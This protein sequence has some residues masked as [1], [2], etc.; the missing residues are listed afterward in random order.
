[1]PGR[2]G[3]ERDHLTK[4][5]DLT[6]FPG[7]IP[8][9][10]GGILDGWKTPALTGWLPNLRDFM[11]A[12]GEL[13][14]ERASINDAEAILELQK[15]AY[16][17]EAELLD[18]FTIPP[19]H[20]TTEEILAEFDR[21]VFLKVELEGRIIASVRCHLEDRT[22]HVGKLI[23][24]PDLRN[25]GLGTRLLRAAESQCPNA[26]RYELFTSAKS[27][28]NLCLYEKCGY[29][30]FERKT[31]SEKVTLVFMEKTNDRMR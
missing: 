9:F 21:Q 12:T 18:D 6:S 17:T 25:R 4:H 14:V 1:M 11:T 2:S 29:R 31:I 3:D 10:R 5:D 13:V 28:K 26:R 20:Q 23:V 22:C 16:L 27:E 8:G 7:C 19:L 15:L 24:H 30:S